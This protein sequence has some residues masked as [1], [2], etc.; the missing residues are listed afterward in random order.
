MGKN[1]VIL[2]MGLDIGGAET[3]I[4]ELADALR[5]QGNKVTIFS[6]GGAF[7]EQLESLGVDHI[8]SPMNNKR[9]SS[10]I[11]SYRA[12]LKFCKNES[13]SRQ[14]GSCSPRRQ[15]KWRHTTPQNK[16]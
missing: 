4:V 14:N 13:W 2:T 10:L 8:T 15:R 9:L 1:I 3:H 16:T 6:N 12:L 5:K 11:R 7:T